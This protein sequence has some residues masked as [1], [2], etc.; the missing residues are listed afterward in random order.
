MIRERIAKTRVGPQSIETAFSLETED[1]SSQARL[2]PRRLPELPE[3]E[4]RSEVNQGRTVRKP[5]AEDSERAPAV[6]RTRSSLLK[7]DLG[8]K[9]R[10]RPPSRQPK[11][12]PEKVVEIPRPAEEPAP[13]PG[14]LHC[15]STDGSRTPLLRQSI[16]TQT[17]ATRQAEG[18]HKCSFCVH[19]KP[20][21]LEDIRLPPLENSPSHLA[22][23]RM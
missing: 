4:G 8:E 15:P 12:A 17:C 11:K 20:R 6:E 22:E 18:Y 19:N 10:K 16:P 2:S 21:P 13:L 5:L 1:R 14:L 7:K 23:S 9:E 3:R